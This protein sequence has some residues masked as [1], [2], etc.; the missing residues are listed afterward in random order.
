[1]RVI[2]SKESLHKLS[3]IEEFITQNNPKRAARFVNYLIKRAES[4]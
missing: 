3:E 1:M 4:V 2:W